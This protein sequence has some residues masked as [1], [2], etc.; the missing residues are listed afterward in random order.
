MVEENYGI[1][2]KISFLFFFLRKMFTVSFVF[3]GFCFD[4][5][6]SADFGSVLLSEF[7]E[8]AKWVEV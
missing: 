2:L 3:S 6:W 4:F 7:W 5:W 1:G 8:E